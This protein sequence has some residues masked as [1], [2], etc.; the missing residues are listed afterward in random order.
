M[1]YDIGIIGGGTAGMT[2]AIYGQ[3]AG[4]RTV[5]IEA[6][7]YGGQITS[8]PNVENYPGIA[9]VSGAEFSMN[10][11]D[12]AMKLGAV[13]T[14]VLSGNGV[15]VLEAGEVPAGVIGTVEPV[16]LSRKLWDGDR[17]V[18]VTDGVLEAC[19]GED[20]EGS[21]REYIEGMEVHSVQEMA[22]ELLQFAC[23]EEG[24]RDDMMVLVGGIWRR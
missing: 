10:L 1:M 6:M 9:S 21:M 8:S 4:K 23:R 11:L 12:Q 17:V 22:E 20:K 13:A 18:M 19:P 24:P 3:R 5:I 14:F 7:N 2:A 16:L 15:E